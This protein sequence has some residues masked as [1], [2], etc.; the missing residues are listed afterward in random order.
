[1][2]DSESTTEL[3][4]PGRPTAFRA[5]PVRS[6]APS[7]RGNTA[8]RSEYGRLQIELLL[9]MRPCRCDRRNSRRWPDPIQGISGWAGGGVGGSSC[10]PIGRAFGHFMA[11]TLA[12]RQP[13]SVG[14][15]TGGGGR[16]ASLGRP[17]DVSTSSLYPARSAYGRPHSAPAPRGSAQVKARRRHRAASFPAARTGTVYI[18]RYLRPIKRTSARKPPAL[19]PPPPTDR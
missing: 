14:D 3:G 13:R 10:G 15:G 9:P 16:G 19:E 11:H 1:M 12:E 17:A 4:Q 5:F 8:I 2:V 18:V 6:G 7:A